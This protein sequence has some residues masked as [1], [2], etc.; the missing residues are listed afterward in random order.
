MPAA[1]KRNA[2]EAEAGDAEAAAPR[3]VLTLEVVDGPAKGVSY[4][5]QVRPSP[6]NTG[7]GAPRRVVVVFFPHYFLPYF[8][9]PPFP[10][11]SPTRT[12]NDGVCARLFLFRPTYLGRTS[13]GSSGILRSECSLH[14]FGPELTVRV[15]LR[16]ARGAFTLVRSTFLRPIFFCLLYRP[17]PLA[18]FASLA[19][20]H[21]P[22]PV[23]MRRPRR[24]LRSCLK[25]QTTLTHLSHTPRTHATRQ[26]DKLQIGR[27]RTSQIHIKGDPAVSQKHAGASHT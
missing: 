22:V 10:L 26:A 17:C 16:R 25:D 1:R 14:S 4:A 2:A 21:D 13:P 6:H 27:T 23:S 12:H 24:C 9:S 15:R 20:A 3:D 11:L 18:L 7:G 8:L 5:K 19:H